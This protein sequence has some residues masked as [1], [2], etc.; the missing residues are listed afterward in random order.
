MSLKQIM[1]SGQARH[2]RGRYRPAQSPTAF[3]NAFGGFA[4]GILMQLGRRDDG[5]SAAT[6]E[7]AMAAGRAGSPGKSLKHD[8][9]VCFS[10]M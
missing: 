7:Q 6:D 3:Q 1:P 8:S 10:Y 5:S 2:R 9:S 4:N